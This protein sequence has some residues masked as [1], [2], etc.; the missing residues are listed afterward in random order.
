MEMGKPQYIRDMKSGEMHLKHA[1]LLIC[2]FGSVGRNMRGRCK[3]LRCLEWEAE[4]GKE[5]RETRII[6]R[7]K[8]RAIT[9]RT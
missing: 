1:M 9:V 4:H 6:G 7:G 3:L 5:R 8:W 2:S